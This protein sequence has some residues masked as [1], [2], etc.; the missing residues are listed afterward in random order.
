MRDISHQIPYQVQQLLDSLVN[1]KDSVHVRSNYR[2][3]LDTIRREID[4]A[5]RQYDTEVNFKDSKRKA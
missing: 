3:R 2:M 5:I 1:K 4:T